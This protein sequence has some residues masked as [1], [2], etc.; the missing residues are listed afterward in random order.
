MSI[1][2]TNVHPPQQ[3]N[4]CFRKPFQ[5]DLVS[6]M[7]E[8]LHT[9]C[10]FE[11]VERTHAIKILKEIDHEANTK[12]TLFF[13]GI[14][15]VAGVIAVMALLVLIE[16]G[17]IL[18]FTLGFF[19]PVLILAGLLVAGG[20]VGTCLYFGNDP[21][22]VNVLFSAYDDLSLDARIYRNQLEGSQD[23]WVIIKA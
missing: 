12:S 3:F 10:D 6:A 22:R 13:S 16:L 19:I 8:K 18:G 4:N 2:I 14:Y 11:I 5:V 9:A 1:T 15:V 7:K 17:A 21:T 20:I 23:K